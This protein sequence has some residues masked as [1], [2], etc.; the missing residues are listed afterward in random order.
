MKV[1]NEQETRAYFQQIGWD[2]QCLPLKEGKWGFARAE[3]SGLITI[4][5]STLVD[6]WE[7][8]RD[9]AEVLMGRANMLE[10]LMAEYQTGDTEKRA[11][12]HE[13]HDRCLLE[14][15]SEFPKV[16]EMWRHAWELE[17]G[18]MPLPRSWRTWMVRTFTEDV[19]LVRLGPKEV[20]MKR[21]DST[22]HLG[23]NLQFLERFAA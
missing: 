14:Q 4:S 23:E 15:I 18:K 22:Q 17:K 5:L 12:I 2:L 16:V 13:W 10:F 11:S 9:Y 1:S 7:W 8:W 6:I 20:F 19:D 3:H 21:L